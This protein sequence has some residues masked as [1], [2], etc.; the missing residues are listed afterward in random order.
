[1]LALIAGAGAGLKGHPTEMP[2]SKANMDGFTDGHS[3]HFML[4]EVDATRGV[5]EG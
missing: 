4:G 5:L 1:L 3:I 2:S